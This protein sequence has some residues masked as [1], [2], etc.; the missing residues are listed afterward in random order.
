[1]ADFRPRRAKLI[2]ALEE[3]AV[4]A[5]V[6]AS[7][8][9]LETLKAFART[10]ASAAVSADIAGGNQ[11]RP[12]SEYLSAMAS[13]YRER[14][15]IVSKNLAEVRGRFDPKLEERSRGAKFAFRAAASIAEKLDAE[16]GGDGF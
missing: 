10:L 2:A 15:E 7:D 5:S 13:L 1:M 14:A 11:W 6:V 8:T 4:E 3:A 16:A 9:E 12:E